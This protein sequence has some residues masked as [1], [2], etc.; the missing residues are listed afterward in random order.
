MID[1]M[2]TLRTLVEKTPDGAIR[3]WDISH[4]STTKR[5]PV[6]D[7]SPQAPNCPHNRGNSNSRPRSAIVFAFHGE[8]VSEGQLNS[9]GAIDQSGSRPSPTP[10]ARCIR[11]T[12]TQRPC[13]NPTPLR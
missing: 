11:M 2:M 5:A 7:W 1:D 3:R 12:S 13:L 10:S 8:G 9:S 4:P 6:N